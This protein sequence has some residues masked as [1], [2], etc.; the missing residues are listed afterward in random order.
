MH[1]NYTPVN[2]LDGFEKS[3]DRLEQIIKQSLSLQDSQQATV[4]ALKEIT[5]QNGLPKGH[6]SDIRVLGKLQEIKELI[7]DN[8]K[9][10]DS[11]DSY[12]P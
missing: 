9:P 2:H 11:D 4:V 12:V 5:R 7:R 6:N 1:T 10:F 8:A 3:L